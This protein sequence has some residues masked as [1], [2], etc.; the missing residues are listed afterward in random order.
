MSKYIT[1][2]F[3][4]QTL[5]DAGTVE[6]DPSFD[7]ENTFEGTLNFVAT[8]TKATGTFAA[9]A[10]LQG[11][12]DGTTFVNIG[13]AVSMTDTVAATIPLGGTILYYNYY[14]VVI[15]G[16]GT[17]STAVVGSWTLKGRD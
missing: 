4:S 11:S 9:S 2:T 13:S 8:G 15:T 5:T 16:S 12:N 6:L 3:A 14:K 7:V 17:Q 1:Q 10:Q